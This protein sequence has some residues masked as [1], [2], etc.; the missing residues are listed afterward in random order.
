LGTNQIEIISNSPEETI[1]IG[2]RIASHLNAGSTV[3]L[4]GTLGSGKTCL[5][6]GIATALGI[7]ETLTSPTYTIIN[8]Y[9]LTNGKLNHIDVYRLEGDRDFEDIGGPEII[10]A[11]GISIIEWSE[12]L[13]KTLP[14]NAITVLIEITGLT[15]RK[16]II[17]GLAE[18]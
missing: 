16:I 10:N 15:S 3:A 14:D 11:D 12:R 7:S 1:N 6:K 17:T 8:E 9:P 5:T 13:E 2:N 4:R 18:L